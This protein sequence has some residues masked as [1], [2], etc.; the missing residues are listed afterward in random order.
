MALGRQAQVMTLK[1]TRVFKDKATGD[2]LREEITEEVKVFQTD[3]GAAKGL[4]SGLAKILLPAGEGPDCRGNYCRARG[5]HRPAARDA[6]HNRQ[7]PPP[8]MIEPR[9]TR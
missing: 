4:A 1:K 6:Y 3:L 2:M 8:P 5:L 9:K 7:P